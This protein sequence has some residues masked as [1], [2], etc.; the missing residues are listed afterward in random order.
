MPHTLPAP[1]SCRHQGG[2]R[3]CKQHKQLSRQQAMHASSSP[4]ESRRRTSIVSSLDHTLLTTA[5][6]HWAINPSRR[7]VVALHCPRARMHLPSA[8]LGT[9][10]HGFVGLIVS[11]ASYL[12]FRR[13]VRLMP[14]PSAVRPGGRSIGCRAEDVLAPAPRVHEHAVC[15]IPAGAHQNTL[16]PLTPQAL[17]SV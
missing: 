17:S 7:S 10:I 6:A 14:P 12:I 8:P 3:R 4:H 16:T 5:M 13:F 11:V 1:R 2:A 9:R 15:D